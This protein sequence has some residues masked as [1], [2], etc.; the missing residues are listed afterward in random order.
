MNGLLY[1]PVVLKLDKVRHKIIKRMVLKINWNTFVLHQASEPYKQGSH[2][3]IMAMTMT[4]T[5][6]HP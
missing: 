4:I 6:P 1:E 3:I 2:K 5:C